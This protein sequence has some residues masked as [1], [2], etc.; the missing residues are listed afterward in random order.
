LCEIKTNM[1]TLYDLKFLVLWLEGKKRVINH[2]LKI[3]C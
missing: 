2:R 1:G 3:D